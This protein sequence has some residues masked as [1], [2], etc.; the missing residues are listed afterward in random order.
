MTHPDLWERIHRG[1]TVTV[2]RK[3][4]QSFSQSDVHFH[5]GT[6]AQVDMV[7]LA[8]GWKTMHSIFS[9]T[10]RLEIGLP[11]TTP[12]ESKSQ[13]RWSALELEANK[14][15]ERT[16]PLLSESPEGEP[17]KTHESYRLY[18]HIV[19]AWSSDDRSLAFIGMLRTAGAPLVYEAQALWAVAYLTGKLS[20]PSK[21]A[22]EREIATTNSWI[23]KRYVCGRKVPFALFDFMPVSANKQP[24]QRRCQV[25]ESNGVYLVH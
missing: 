2:H 8:T 18:R 23:H 5:D 25:F 21:E 14:L 11:S 12:F 17:K 15:V 20:L 19:P 24:R 7:I 9:P 10:D 1:G 6:K 16:F 13:E 4:V 22:M 3:A